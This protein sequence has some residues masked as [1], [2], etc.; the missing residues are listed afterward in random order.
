MKKILIVHTGGTIAMSEDKN[1]GEVRPTSANPLA[2]PIDSLQGVEI[3]SEDFLNIP[4]PHM[5]IDLMVSLAHFI[6]QEVTNHHYDGIVVTHGTD[7]LEET[8]YLLD[9]II[10]SKCPVVV[11]GAMR[12]SNELGSDGPPNLLSAVR[13]AMSE[14]AKNK[15][16]LVVLNDE[17]HT[18]KNATKTHTS[19]I[20]TFQS[21]Q[22]GPIGIVTKRD[23]HFHHAPIVQE[24]FSATSLTKKV[25]LIKAVA[26]MEKEV[27]ESVCHINMDGLVLEALG[28]G[29]M[30]PETVAPIEKLVT[31][32]IPV[33]L[34]S[35]CF[36][37]IVQDTYSYD[38]GGRHLKN[39][40]VIF[41]NGLNGQK[42]RIKL[43]AA[44]EETTDLLKLQEIF[45]Q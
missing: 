38:G 6:D 7:T 19:N 23:I 9:L 24:K 28:Q 31:K 40:G 25:L 4:S 32:G 29:N 18:A 17:I 20:A 3:K 2:L 14:A 5:T 30:P 44:L 37:G 22:Y 11:T 21:P 33:V 45:Q 43:M 27:L 15:G 1:T 35:R 8:A 13:T 36:N 10:K 26:G 42:A 41:T 34:V 16:V 39:I 12:S